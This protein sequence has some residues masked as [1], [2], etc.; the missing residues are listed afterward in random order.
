MADTTFIKR[1]IEPYVLKWLSKEFASHKFEEQPLPL[2]PAGGVHKFDAV[3][4]DKTIVGSILSN[5]PFTSTGREN[6]GAV[7]KVL[8]DF[9]LLSLLPQSIQPILVFTDGDFCALA[10]KRTKRFGQERIRMLVCPLPDNLQAELTKVL[11]AASQEQR[12]AGGPHR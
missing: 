9:H 6:A 2:S 11:N 10:R 7:R 4:E 8:N 3:S 5:R 1:E 12:A